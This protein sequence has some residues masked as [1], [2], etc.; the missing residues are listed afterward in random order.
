MAAISQHRPIGVTIQ[1][2]G[3]QPFCLGQ[4]IALHGGGD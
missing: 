3:M 2:S 4:P 1:T